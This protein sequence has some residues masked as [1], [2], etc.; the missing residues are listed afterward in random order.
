MRPAVTTLLL[1]FSMLLSFSISR[2]YILC[3]PQSVGGGSEPLV[4]DEE[5]HDVNAVILMVSN[6][7]PIGNNRSTGDGWGFFP[8]GT[9]NNYVYGTGLWFG[10]NYDADDDGDRDKVF[11]QGYN[12]LAG[13]TEFREGRGDQEPDDPLTRIFRSDVPADL[14]NWPPQFSD[15]LTSEPIVYSDQDFVTTYTTQDKDPIFGS[16]QLPLEVD[17]R[18]MAVMSGLMA[19]VIFLTFEVQNTG[20]KVLEDAWIGYDSDMDVGNEFADDLGSVIFDRFTPGGDTVGLD[21]GYAWDSDFT[22]SNFT[23]DPGFVGMSF[24]LTPGN[25]DDGIDNDGDGLTDESPFNSVDDDGDSLIDEWDEVD[26]I[27]LVNFS[28]HCNPS[29]PCEVNDPEDDPTGYAILSCN[30]PGDTITCLE[31]TTPADIRFMLSSGPFDW[32]PGQ[33][34][35]I[36]FAM[37]FANAVGDPTELAFVGDPPRPDPNDPALGDLVQ[38]AEQA[39]DYFMTLFPPLGI[40]DD[41]SGDPDIGL[42]RAFV[43]YQNFPNPFNPMTTIR[44]EIAG[45][46]GG[47]VDLGI[48]NMRGQRVRTLVDGAQALGP[49]EVRWDGRD[50]FNQALPSGPYLYRL[51]NGDF[52]ST[53]R[54]NLVK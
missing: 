31:S 10:A 39:H 2:A 7:G 53:R 48:F 11:T 54:M 14:E 23:G 24:I 47:P 37:V 26:E 27:G 17:Q 30:A 32:Q 35:L 40:G 43:L 36:G 34:Q 3:D 29:L 50:A 38:V 42:P 51:R 12:P 4:L 1:V 15:S 49:H 8:A 44:Y 5:F 41:P 33:S 45:E 52:V 21:M 9:P 16:F 19:Q 25:P 28:K 18:S 46:G 20:D 22:E 13:D 6:Q